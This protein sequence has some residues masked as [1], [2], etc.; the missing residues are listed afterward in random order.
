M[1]HVLL[2]YEKEYALEDFVGVV[3]TRKQFNLVP[4]ADLAKLLADLES[5]VK[6]AVVE[7]ILVT[8]VLK[9][10]NSFKRK[11]KNGSKNKHLSH[12]LKEPQ[13]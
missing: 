6:M 4:V 11:A 10:I 7:K 2:F 12:K 3:T 1:P 13:K 8:P 9:Q 5:V